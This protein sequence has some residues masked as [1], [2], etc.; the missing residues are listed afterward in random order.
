MA[1]GEPQINLRVPESLKAALDAAVAS[2]GRSLNAEVVYRLEQSFAVADRDNHAADALATIIERLGEIE[3][4]IGSRENSIT[5]PS[6]ISDDGG[7]V[8]VASK[9]KASGKP[10]RA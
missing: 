7:K 6:E 2:G 8:G 3:K 9:S 5:Q 1:R 10:K 4:Q